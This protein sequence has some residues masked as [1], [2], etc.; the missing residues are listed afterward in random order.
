MYT[1]WYI[2]LDKRGD[3]R[4]NVRTE[5]WYHAEHQYNTFQKEHFRS[6]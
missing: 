5:D 3:V 4:Y 1:K 6:A 2:S